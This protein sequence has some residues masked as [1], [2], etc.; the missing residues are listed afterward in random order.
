MWLAILSGTRAKG[1]A[2]HWSHFSSHPILANP[3]DF[4]LNIG[5]EFLLLLA[6]WAVTFLVCATLPLRLLQ[7][8]STCSSASIVISS[9]PC[10]CLLWGDS[11][12][13]V[14]KSCFLGTGKKDHRPTAFPNLGSVHLAFLPG[15]LPGSHAAA[16]ESL[17][18]T[19]SPSGP[20]LASPPLWQPSL[21]RPHKSP[22]STSCLLALHSPPVP[23]SSSCSYHQF[24]CPFW[25]LNIY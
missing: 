1:L 11:G 22:A 12:H 20:S 24:S 13:I 6:L 17:L 18:L 16:P 14:P 2:L 3:L 21:P 19:A 4:S 15:H 9:S 25:L 23:Y 8:A 5:L 10:C 7:R